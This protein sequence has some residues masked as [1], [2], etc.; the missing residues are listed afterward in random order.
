MSL[1]TLRERSRLPSAAELDGILWLG[2][3]SA[4]HR[5][6]AAGAMRVVQA[7]PGEVLCRTG[8][9]A[10]YWFGVVDGLLKMSSDAGDAA[11]PDYGIQQELG[12]GVGGGVGDL[13]A[14]ACGHVGPDEPDDRA[15]EAA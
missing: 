3:L 8:R 5:R 10:V 7:E 14:A 11:V 15:E 2:T 6:L 9:P 12:A 13:D 4:S 1:M